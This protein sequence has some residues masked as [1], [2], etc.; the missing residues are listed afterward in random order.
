MGFLDRLFGKSRELR[1][2]P[3]ELDASTA[4]E[5]FDADGNRFL[6]SREE[7]ERKVLPENFQQHWNDA[8]ALY[9]LIIGTL[10]DG[11]IDACVAPAARLSDIHPDRET[12]CVIQSI[13]HVKT[14]AFESA[15]SCLEDFIR[16]NGE[17][18]VLVC[19]LAQ[20]YAAMGDHERA[21]TTLWNAITLD[22]NLDT[23]INWWAAI[24]RETEG[25]A[26]FINAMKAI[27]LLPGSWRADIWIA[28][29]L[30]TKK[31]IDSAALIYR[32]VLS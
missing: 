14:G 22:P 3:P 26:G 24:A 13:V 28:R 21:R 6:M 27:A 2:E 23:A 17:T 4:I 20:A 29:D 7:Y 12:A 25:D 9:Q 30:L 8:D 10:R 16:T 11:F 15:I 5:L 32:R 18:G 19:N 31:K 1:P